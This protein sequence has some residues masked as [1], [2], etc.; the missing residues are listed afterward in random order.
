V[1]DESLYEKREQTLAKHEILRKYLE[2]FAHTV[3]SAWPSI[4]YIDCFSGPWNVRSSDLK[5]SSFAIALQ[6]LRKARESLD[7]RGRKIALRCLFLERDAEAYQQ[8]EEFSRSAHDV[9]VKA[10]NLEFEKSINE[11]VQFVKSGGNSFPFIF[12]DP[13]GWTGFAMTTIAPLL[14]LRPV[15]VLVNFMTGHITRF[16]HSPQSKIQSSFESLFGSTEFRPLL[17]GIEGIDLEDQAVALY[18]ENLRRRGNFDY[19][20]KAV[21]LNPEKNRSHFHLVY[22]TRNSEGVAVFKE[23]E[24]RAMSIMESARANAQRRRRVERTRQFE[25][26]LSRP[27]RQSAYFES[28]RKRYLNRARDA[29]KTLLSEEVRVQYDRAWARALSFQLVWESDLKEWIQDWQKQPAP[30]KGSLTIEGLGDRERTPK[31]NRNHFLVW[32]IGPRLEA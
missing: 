10:L 9:E 18:S 23:A 15:E 3:G 28:L 19:S 22:A 14:Q 30:A 27:T 16:L 4:T 20:S 24:R 2:G 7:R 11:I 1:I 12:I 26:P 8:L 17:E 32:H 29:V 5:D 13:T 25:M 6:E 21:V 31:R